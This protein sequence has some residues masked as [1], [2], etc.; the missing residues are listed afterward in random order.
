M[1]ITLRETLLGNINELQA[2]GYGVY[3]DNKPVTDNILNTETQKDKPTYKLWIWDA[4]D[5]IKSE[6]HR[7]NRDR[8]YGFGE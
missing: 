3:D 7:H 8:L 2:K 1:R 4:I 6:G 5:C